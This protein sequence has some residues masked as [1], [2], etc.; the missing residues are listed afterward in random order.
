MIRLSLSELDRVLDQNVD[1]KVDS[2]D[3]AQLFTALDADSNGV[4]EGTELRPARSGNQ[5]SAPESFRVAD[6]AQRAKPPLIQWQRTLDDAL[7]LQKKTGQPLLICVNMDGEP[8]ERVAGLVPLPR[9]RV[10]AADRGL[11]VPDRLA[12][13]PHADR[14]RR[15]RPAPARSALRARDRERAR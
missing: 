12:R 15:P 13:P 6:D 7:E 2:N 9:P 14:P 5:G 10:R 4:V 11:R 1:G 8:A 3:L